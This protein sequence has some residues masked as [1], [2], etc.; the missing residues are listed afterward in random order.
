M[1]REYKKICEEKR[2]ER[3]RWK[4]E[5]ERVKTERQVW[6]VVGTEKVEEEKDG[7]GD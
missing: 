1:K 6:K 7:R 3:E 2:R 5:M 4:R